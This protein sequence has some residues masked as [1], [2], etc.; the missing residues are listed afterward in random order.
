MV[1]SFHHHEMSATMT[2]FV[3]AAAVCAG[4]A[5]SSDSESITLA[6]KSGWR[7][8]GV[9]D[10]A[11]LANHE[12]PTDLVEMIKRCEDFK[13]LLGMMGVYPDGYTTASLSEHLSRDDPL[14]SNFLHPDA[15]FTQFTDDG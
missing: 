11:D 13:E 9:S 6:G 3:K 5:T 10:P 8:P 15:S 1:T 14:P 7:V 4:L 2:A 12:A